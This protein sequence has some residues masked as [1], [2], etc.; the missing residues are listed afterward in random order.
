M[1]EDILGKTAPTITVTDQEFDA[2]DELYFVTTFEQLLQSLEWPPD[3]LRA[4]LQSLLEKDWIRCYLDH[5]QE[6]LLQEA[7]FENHYQSYYYLASKAGLLAH[8]GR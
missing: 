3:K 8:N 4:V 1:L 5:S 6:L 7:D 2:L